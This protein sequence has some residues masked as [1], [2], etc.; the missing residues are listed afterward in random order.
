MSFDDASTQAR[1]EEVTDMVVDIWA[2]VLEI[3]RSTIDPRESDFFALGGYSL[4]IL[5]SIS[6]LLAGQGIGEEDGQELEGLL[7]NEL[8]ENPTAAAQAECLL[9]NISIQA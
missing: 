4:L 3:D 6:R 9:R 5:Q 2:D 7:L 1:L 8:F